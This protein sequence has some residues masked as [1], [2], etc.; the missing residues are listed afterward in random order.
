MDLEDFDV[1]KVIEENN[2]L[3]GEN[4]AK[5]LSLG[6]EQPETE[7]QNLF[8]SMAKNPMVMGIAKQMPLKI[9]LLIGL[10]VAV[11]L[12]GAITTINWMYELVI[13]YP[14]VS[15]L[16]A[17]IILLLVVVM[18]IVRIIKKKKKSKKK[19][20]LINALEIA[21]DNIDTMDDHQILK[22]IRNAKKIEEEIK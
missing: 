5:N 15:T 9:K 7:K 18:D 12:I 21:Q 20:E 17:S 1:S 6:I 19:E 8:L 4:K 10:G 2:K 22:V 13:T 16:T 11:L 3:E 14:M